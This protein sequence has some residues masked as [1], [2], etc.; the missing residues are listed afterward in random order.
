[1][2]AFERKIKAGPKSTPALKVEKNISQSGKSPPHLFLS[3]G[4]S[5]TL[6][7]TKKI[8]TQIAHHL[9]RLD[10]TGPNWKKPD[11][12]LRQQRG[13]VKL[14]AVTGCSS[15]TGYMPPVY[16]IAEIAHLYDANILAAGAQLVPPQSGKP[17]PGHLGFFSPQNVCS[18]LFVDGFEGIRYGTQ[19]EDFSDE[20][21]PEM[22]RISFGCY[23]QPT[24]IDR[25][26]EALQELVHR[27]R[28]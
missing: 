9:I 6:I 25:L 24:E 22:V 16:T 13:N 4:G 28:R 21:L 26:C 20:A 10:G 11:D 12:C 7:V 14:A 2:G 19:K 17:T 8:Y 27:A 1:M 18:L 3:P 5:I 23:N 15:F